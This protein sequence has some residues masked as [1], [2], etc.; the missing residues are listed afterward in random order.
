MRGSNH[1]T[2]QYMS[3]YESVCL[4]PASLIGQKGRTTL[5]PCQ[6][7]LTI[8]AATRRTP[9]AH[10]GRSGGMPDLY[11]ART[12]A[13]HAPE[14]CGLSSIPWHTGPRRTAPAG[15]TAHTGLRTRG[16][17]PRSARSLPC[18]PHR[19]QPDCISC[20]LPRMPHM[21]PQVSGHS[22]HC[23]HCTSLSGCRTG[24]NARP[25]TLRTSSHPAGHSLACTGLSHS[26]QG[27]I[28]YN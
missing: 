1:W 20:K 16:T 6:H 13:P 15:C 24:H 2:D 19:I 12:P 7:R 17:G 5:S 11:M 9:L 8:I 14:Q 18:T 28:S 25:D 3:G 23:R 26:C 27:P 21:Y 10:G 22:P 4:C